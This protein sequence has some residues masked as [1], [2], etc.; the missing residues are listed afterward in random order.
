MRP[1]VSLVF[2][3]LVQAASA[4]EPAPTP[5]PRK[6]DLVEKTERRLVQI[7]VTA[8]GPAADISSLTREDFTLVVNGEWIES[9]TVDR[10]CGT[11]EGHSATHVA[12]ETAQQPPPTIPPTGTPTFLLYF[13]QHHLSIAGRQTA[14][15]D[16][17]R[18]IPDLV[19]GGG[20]V[21]I[22][23]S[24]DTVDV[25]CDFTGDTTRLETTLDRL[26]GDRH[27]WD[28]YPG[29]E[30]ARIR[31]L[32]Q[33]EDKLGHDFACSKALWLR[34]ME[35]YRTEKA[36]RRFAM[37]LGLMAEA[38]PPKSALYFADTVRRDAGMHYYSYIGACHTQEVGESKIPHSFDAGH[39]LD[40]IIGTASSFG[41]RLYTIQAEGLVSDS[42]AVPSI[43]TPL[44]PGTPTPRVKPF[45]PNL[46]RVRQAQEALA[47]MA[48]ETGGRAF[49][50]GV[51]A[52][53]MVQ[54][55]HDDVACVYLISFDGAIFKTDAP[56]SVR[57]E[58][59][60]PKIE[61][62]TRGRLVLPSESE[63][64]S[65]RLMTAF[66]APGSARKD[67]NLRGTLIPIGFEHGNYRALVQ[68]RAP[69]SPVNEAVWDLGASLVSGGEI[70]QDDS[71]RLSIREAGV[72]VVFESEMTFEPGP[73]ELIL[74][75]H[76][77]TSN[78]LGSIRLEGSWP[79]RAEGPAIGPI[80]VVQKSP[81]S[82]FL[83][84]EA[85]RVGGSLARGDKE[86]VRIDEPTALLTLVCRGKGRPTLR[87]ARRLE[88]EGVTE[89]PATDVAFK[90]EPEPCVQ[91]RDMIPAGT[92]SEGHFDYKIR[93]LDGETELATAT[94]AIYA[95]GAQDASPGGS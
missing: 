36:L 85:S 71:G 63:R 6:I 56:L 91:I 25:L 7:D 20:R 70:R 15:D 9:F 35:L 86:T 26:E 54:A 88:G 57:V 83:R 50:N 22:A 28:E 12:A 42:M 2:V 93:I 41:V 8:R 43:A 39:V 37:I 64:R 55:I 24:G 78:Q 66:V 65:A 80:A 87:I 46:Q 30:E 76:D 34:Q 5:E 74:V 31:Q 62:Q 77:T 11:Q 14:I 72:P 29:L 23:S 32:L 79:E 53:R 81:G 48:L 1:G 58:T 10:L 45:N 21:A 90:D 4:Q 92:M 84:G 44:T 16:A 67:L 51:S 59:K 40:R 73:Y 3:A 75:A 95:V 82:V 17:R 49:L 52:P 33:D 61:L 18:M 68:V 69:A 38:D 19:H 47:G 94:R 27:H 13:D 60:R 89:F